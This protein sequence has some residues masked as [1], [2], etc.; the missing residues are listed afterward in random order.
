MQVYL[1]LQLLFSFQCTK[2]QDNIEVAFES[3]ALSDQDQWQS[4]ILIAAESFVIK[5]HPHHHNRH[6]THYV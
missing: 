4:G 2:N 1:R 5:V 3:P 6:I